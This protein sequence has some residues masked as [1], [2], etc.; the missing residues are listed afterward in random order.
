[1]TTT[2]AQ[3]AA[4]TRA[5]P[6]TPKQ[7]LFALE[8]LLDFNGTQAATR[9][10]YSPRSAEEQARQLLR[11]PGVAD[12]VEQKRSKVE[13]SLGITREAVIGELAKIG[14]SNMLDYVAIGADGMPR[15]DLSGLT[16]DQAAA[17]QEITLDQVSSETENGAGAAGPALRRTTDRIKI[18]LAP[19][20]EALVDLGKHLGVFRDD[21]VPAQP[22]VFII[23]GLHGAET[24]KIRQ[25]G[26]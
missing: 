17:I 23:E 13:E 5:R 1:M 26:R 8:Y 18:K 10:G 9:A 22:V 6:L 7:R 16:R 15:T 20:R 14:F 3:Q 11:I 4:T 25:A 21:G 12:L 19:K 2:A 24:P